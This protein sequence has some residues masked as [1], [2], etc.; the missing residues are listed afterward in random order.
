MS[1]FPHL[2][3]QPSWEGR[4]PIPPEK[5]IFEFEYEFAQ[6]MQK[7]TSLP[8]AEIICSYTQE[9]KNNTTLFNSLHN[10]RVQREN[11]PW[12]DVVNFAF[13]QSYEDSLTRDDVYARIA[14][15]ET[16][17]RVGCFY[18]DYPSRLA[19]NA[20]GIHFT[21]CELDVASP[22]SEEKLQVRRQEMRELLKDVLK[23]FPS[24]QTVVGK[25]W[26]YNVPA[27]RHF[28]P[29][30]YLN[31]LEIDFNEEQWGRG[32]T[33]WGQFID[34]QSKLKTKQAEAFLSRLRTLPSG[35]PLSDLYSEDGVLL[36]PLTTYGPIEDFYTMYGIH[37]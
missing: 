27:Y 10:K 6:I 37:Q 12:D 13:T 28:F 22:L 33:I 21:N 19:E 24:V 2:N 34:S 26:L 29:T 9:L 15:T 31:G 25:S 36:P 32:S 11:V 18:F 16:F 14:S 4:K 35:Q 17:G 30:S 3:K 8:L 23:R 7:R 20:I 5:A 1:E